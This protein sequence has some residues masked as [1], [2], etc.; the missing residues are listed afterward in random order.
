MRYVSCS[1]LVKHQTIQ[2]TQ[3]PYSPDLAPCDFWLFP[4]LK[5]PLK[6]KRFQT[7]SEIQ[8]NMMGQLI[9]IGRTV[10]CPKVPTLKETKAS[11]SYA[12]CFLY[13]VSFIYKC[14]FCIL[15]GWVSSGQISYTYFSS[16]HGT[17]FG[18]D[19]MLGHKTSLNK[20]KKIEI[21]AGISDYNA[22]KLEVSHKN[23]EKHT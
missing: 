6:E 4:K 23:T 1:F 20:F 19:H 21:I 18:I 5:S 2:V 22:V 11:L 16:A 8:G 9:A 3:P 15:H 7:I 13:L 10:W 14:L 12:H 17:F